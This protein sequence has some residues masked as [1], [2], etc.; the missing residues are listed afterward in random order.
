MH[1]GF[2]SFPQTASKLYGAFRRLV[3]II[4]KK[5]PNIVKKARTEYKEV[6]TE[7]LQGSI[8]YN[9][10]STE[11]KEESTEYNG[12]SIRKNEENAKQSLNRI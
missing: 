11:Y 6:I 12:V 10:L 4:S 2:F 8:E 5:V 9:G 1:S 7:Q 3:P